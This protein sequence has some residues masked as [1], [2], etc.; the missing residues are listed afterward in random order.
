M[1]IEILNCS[2]SEVYI[3]NPSM[4][5]TYYHDDRVYMCLYY[6][7]DVDLEQVRK[8]LRELVIF[9]ESSPINVTIPHNHKILFKDC[10]EIY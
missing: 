2:T 10:P 5:E 6:D 4:C 8:G 7:E 3:A 1:K 9:G